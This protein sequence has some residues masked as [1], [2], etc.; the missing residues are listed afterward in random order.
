M[1]DRNFFL[2]FIRVH[3]LYHA[4]KEPIYGVELIEELKRH[5]Y[6]LS[7]GTLYPIL[8]RLEEESLLITEYRIVGGK[9]R[10]YYSLTDKGREMLTSARKQI[11]ELMNEVMQG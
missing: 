9:R 3:I 6:A 10:R 2:G 8:H 1:L 5:G 7:P 11:G 4:S